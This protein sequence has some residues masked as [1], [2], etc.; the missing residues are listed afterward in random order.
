MRKAGTAPPSDIFRSISSIPA[1]GF[2]FETIHTLRALCLQRAGVLT[3]PAGP[4]PRRRTRTSGCRPA[5]A[6]RPP[7]GGAICCHIKVN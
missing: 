2:A 5:R 6:P 3:H 7:L 4:D 1:T